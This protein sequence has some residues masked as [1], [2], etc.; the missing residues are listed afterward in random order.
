MHIKQQNSR[1]A[2]MYT[3]KYIGERIIYNSSIQIVASKTVG[4]G[5]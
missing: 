2:A 4:F 5:P 1:H 3:A